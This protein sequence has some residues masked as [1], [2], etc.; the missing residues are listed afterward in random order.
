MIGALELFVVNP[1]EFI[2]MIIFN[3]HYYHHLQILI[4]ILLNYHR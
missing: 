3:I 1:N 4:P 2:R